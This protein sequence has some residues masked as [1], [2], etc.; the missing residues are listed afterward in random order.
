IRYSESGKTAAKLPKFD[1]DLCDGQGNICVRMTG[2]LSR[3]LEGELGS[4][5]SQSVPG[6]LMLRPCWQEQGPA[7]QAAGLEYDRQL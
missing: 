1:I 5:G 4:A 2:F 6:T 7:G 3:V